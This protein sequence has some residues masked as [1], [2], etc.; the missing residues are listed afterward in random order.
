M[1][2]AARVLQRPEKPHKPSVHNSH[3][4]TGEAP[5]ICPW[6]AQQEADLLTARLG[7]EMKLTTTTI[8]SL[9]LPPG[10]RDKTFFD[11]ELAGFGVRIREGGSRTYVI[12]Y[13]IG[14]KHRRMPLGSV[15]A[16]EPGRARATAKD[17]LAAVR[18]GQDP[19]GDKLEQRQKI[20]A[21]FGALC[22]RAISPTNGP[23]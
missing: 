7:F 3:E 18:L 17:L 20:S 6:S 8:R 5:E 11:S 22:C 23:D 4:R 14:N 1:T 16:I 13:K 19:A 10:M 9:A 12:Q 2:C 15:T 21:T